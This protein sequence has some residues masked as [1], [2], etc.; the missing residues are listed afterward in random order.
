M[1]K[2]FEYLRE[3]KTELFKV[4]WPSRKETVK[5]TIIVVIFS[6]IVALFLGSV[7]FGLSKFIERLIT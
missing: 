5:L 6:V 3:V 4:V 1:N 7:D 2:L